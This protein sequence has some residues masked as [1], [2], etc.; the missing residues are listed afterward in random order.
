MRDCLDIGRLSN[1]FIR[2][3]ST[4]RVDEVGSKECVDQSRFAESRLT[5][6]RGREEEEKRESRNCQFTQLSPFVFLIRL[7]LAVR[8]LPSLEC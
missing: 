6:E 1:K 8:I 4:L 2:F 3:E 7:P 5:C